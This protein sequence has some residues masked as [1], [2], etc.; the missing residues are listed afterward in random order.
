MSCVA[1][2]QS[3]NRISNQQHSAACKSK[4]GQPAVNAVVVPGSLVYVKADGDKTKSRERYLVV[5]VEGNSCTVQK[6]AN[7]QLRSKTY[8]LKLSE[9]FPVQSELSPV[10]VI[11]LEDSDSESETVVPFNN[12]SS[13]DIRDR[14]KT[15]SVI[16]SRIGL[17][18]NYPPPP[19]P[20]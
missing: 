10:T 13:R 2:N 20:S 14:V 7:T 11:H 1:E 18:K 9:V 15:V 3:T 5:K 8:Q 19:P 16:L 4:G 12:T 6:I 17:L